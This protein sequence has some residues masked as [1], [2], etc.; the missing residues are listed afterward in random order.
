MENIKVAFDIKPEGSR[1]PVNYTL[2]TVHLIFDVR[3]TLERKARWVKDGHKTP[4]PELSTF[5]GVVSRESVRIAFT[6]AALNGLTVCASYIQNAYLQAPASEKHYVIC[7]PEFSLENI[8]K[9]A[10]IVRTLY[11]G[12][13]ANAD[14]W[15]HIILLTRSEA[16]L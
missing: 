6:Y 1:P 16:G 11:G 3:M 14:Y 4:I 5:A 8:G 7:G 2:A 13:S 12:K 9:I 10:V 15:R